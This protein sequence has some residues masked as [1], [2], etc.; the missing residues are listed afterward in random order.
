MQFWLDLFN[1]LI[2]DRETFSLLSLPFSQYMAFLEYTRHNISCWYL[3][4]NVPETCEICTNEIPKD[5]L[6]KIITFYSIL[7]VIYKL[8]QIIQS[9]YIKIPSFFKY[10][11]KMIAHHLIH[12]KGNFMKIT[13][14]FSLF[15]P[16]DVM[17]VWPA[18]FI[19]YIADKG[20]LNTY[21]LPFFSGCI[22]L[23]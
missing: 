4:I 19:L 6:I 7:N 8:Y 16:E 23:F 21:L 17:Q 1:L 11:L 15:T 3:A 18:L 14:G 22:V 5:C 13:S 20:I 10:S 2:A 9:K 12:D